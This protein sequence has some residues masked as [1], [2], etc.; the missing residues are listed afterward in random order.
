MKLFALATNIQKS[1]VDHYHGAM[2]TTTRQILGYQYAEAKDQAIGAFV[3]SVQD[4]KE[5][6][7]F[8]VGQVVSMEI[9]N[10]EHLHTSAKRYEFIRGHRLSG[11]LALF[12]TCETSDVGLDHA[13]DAA[14]AKEAK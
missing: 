5:N 14:L 6:E 3:T 13:I 2:K 9:P 11:M 8:L 7:G 10:I 1:V 4:D 12:P